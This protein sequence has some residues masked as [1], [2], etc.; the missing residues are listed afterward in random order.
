M[1]N[2]LN[3][4]NGIIHIPF[5]ELPIKSF[6]EV[7]MLTWSWSANSIESGQTA[8]ICRLAWLYTGAKTNH[9]WFKQDKGFK[10]NHWYTFCI[11]LLTLYI[12]IYIS[13]DLYWFKIYLRYSGYSMEKFGS[14][15]SLQ[16]AGLCAHMLYY[17]WDNAACDFLRSYAVRIAESAPLTCNKEIK[18]VWKL[19]RNET[20]FVV[21]KL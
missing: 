9:F 15:S 2:L 16:I 13:S 10:A 6:K 8:Q 7:K 4:L 20:Y 3:F 14:L 5:L 19:S 1:L 12:Y 11:R 21:V 18:I 17:N